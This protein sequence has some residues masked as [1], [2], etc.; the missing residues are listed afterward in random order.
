M[1]LGW[2]AQRSAL[3]GALRPARGGN[4]V[5]LVLARIRSAVRD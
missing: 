3:G 2:L 4:D 5:T 1:L